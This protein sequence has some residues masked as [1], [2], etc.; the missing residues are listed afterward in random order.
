MPFPSLSAKGRR[1]G[2]A[3]ARPIGI[4]LRNSPLK[5]AFSSNQ[6]GK[7]G[8]TGNFNLV[9]NYLSWLIGNADF[10]SEF[11]NLMRMGSSA[12][13]TH[14]DAP[15]AWRGSRRRSSHPTT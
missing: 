9:L 6:L 14:Q 10:Q 8:D 7:T 5:G 3:H 12:C 2:R 4:K 13:E 15:T 1:V 11:L